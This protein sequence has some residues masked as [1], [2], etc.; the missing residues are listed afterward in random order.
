[1]CL[2]KNLRYEPHC[3]EEDE[4]MDRRIAM[5]GTLAK[6]QARARGFPTAE[7]NIETRRAYLLY[8]DGHR[9]YAKEFLRELDSEAR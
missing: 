7:Y 4:E 3:G 6:Q 9:G 5:V 1:M 2:N 8:P